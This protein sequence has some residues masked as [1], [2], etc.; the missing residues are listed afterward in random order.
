MAGVEDLV[1][2]ARER[3]N[4]RKLKESSA[5]PP[6]TADIIFQL[7]RFCNLRRRDDRVSRWLRKHVLLQKYIDY[8]LRSFLQFSAWARLMNW[9]PTVEAAI[10][11]GF[12]PRHR[13]NWKGLGKFVDQRGKKQKVFT[14]A[15]MLPASKV[16][17]KKKGKFISELV[18]GKNLAGVVGEL[19]KVFAKPPA[20]RSCKEVWFI[21]R[22]CKFLGFFLSGQ[23]VADWSYTSLLNRAS[24]LYTW[25][26]QGPGSKRGFNRVMG[27]P[28]KTK[29]SQEEW[30]QTLP[31]WRREI[32]SALGPEYEDLDLQSCQNV[33]CE[34]DKYLRVKNGEGRP[35]AK[36][37]AHEY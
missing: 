29:I 4:I 36:Y 3:E 34:C 17:G 24:D 20:L 16:K 14:G 23:I 18:V 26:A 19:Q 27:R 21:L 15:F 12:Y 28:I 6:W 11:E 8:D 1:Y 35:R 32:I 37:R 2:F 10:A 30:D 5:P 9:P 22:K 31:L 7:Y 25:A 13:L 33:L